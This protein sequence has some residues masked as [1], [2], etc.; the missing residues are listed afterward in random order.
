MDMDLKIADRGTISR[1]PVVDLSFQTL[2]YQCKFCLTFLTTL[3]KWE[4]HVQRCI[5]GTAAA[6]DLNGFQESID[7]RC[8]FR[9][10]KDFK[11]DL[12]LRE[13]TF[14][15]PI[16]ILERLKENK[17][18]VVQKP[19]N[20]GK[21]GESL[22]KKR[23]PKRK[24]QSWAALLNDEEIDEETI[25]KLE[26]VTDTEWERGHEA[27]PGKDTVKISKKS[28]GKEENSKPK[29]VCT[30]K[31]DGS[32]KR[33]RNRLYLR[34]KVD[35][36]SLRFPC[37][38]CPGKFY[39]QQELDVHVNSIHHGSRKLT[40]CC[41]CGK[42]FNR[43]DSINS[44]YRAHE[45]AEFV[46]N[47]YDLLQP[48][49]SERLKELYIPKPGSKGKHVTF[50]QPKCYFCLLPHSSFHSYV[51]HIRVEHS[52]PPEAYR[53]A[54]TFQE[55]LESFTSIHALLNHAKA[56]HPHKFYG[57]MTYL[58]MFKGTT[59]EKKVA[60]P[61]RTAKKRTLKE[62]SKTTKRKQK[63]PSVP[64]GKRSTSKQ[65]LRDK[66]SFKQECYKSNDFDNQRIGGLIPHGRKIKLESTHHPETDISEESYSIK[67]EP[68]DAAINLE[69]TD[70][71]DAAK[72][73]GLFLD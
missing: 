55:C 35:V 26:E 64:R 40:P 44:H 7:Q 66:D 48:W 42:I 51:T 11:T 17:F 52:D 15:Q 27:K 72:L 43:R 59:T 68:V 67:V 32:W 49:S 50:M 36:R 31:E 25:T 61:R 24:T 10:S 60:T 41:V 65:P 16:L 29:W 3:S 53:F 23:V 39:L 9:C 5:H 28:K 2:F 56:V 71:F 1:T 46:K 21:D 37:H 33:V 38:L 20:C 73:D 62:S 45:N 58:K 70:S 63:S 19:E 34:E 69:E 14:I 18:K 6:S 47:K 30:K 4:S 54:C 57:K 8:N 22:V 12:G 13:V